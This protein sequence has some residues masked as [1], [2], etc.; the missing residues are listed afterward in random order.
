M[1]RKYYYLLEGIRVLR[2]TGIAPVLVYHNNG[3]PV[4]LFAMADSEESAESIRAA[5]EKAR[6][7]LEALGLIVDPGEHVD[8]VLNRDPTWFAVLLDKGV[9][10]HS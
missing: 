6:P 5:M 1:R 9:G 4:T 7:V 8:G 3:K 10:H 2:D